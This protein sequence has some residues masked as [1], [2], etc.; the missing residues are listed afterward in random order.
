[1]CAAPEIILSA[2]SQRT[3]KIRLGIAV[4]MSPIHHPLHI[5]VK[6]A[7]LDL[8]SNGR[9]DLGVGRSTTPL[10]LTP[11]GVKLEDTRDMV[12]EAL[13]LIPRMWT[14]EVFSHQ[15]KYYD[16]PPC[17]WSP[18]RCKSPIHRCG[19]RAPKKRPAV[20]LGSWGLA[21]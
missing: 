3:S 11:F 14:E 13:S 18:S 16:I 12:D 20:S 9:V 7:T 4:V 15:G 5:A 19:W 8:L 21:A 6:A 2:I 1:M 10:Q 17:R